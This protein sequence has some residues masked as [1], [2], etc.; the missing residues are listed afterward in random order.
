MV[1]VIFFSLWGLKK[2]RGD[3]EFV[4]LV[5]FSSFFIVLFFRI[6]FLQIS[7]YT[8]KYILLYVYYNLIC[9]ILYFSPIKQKGSDMK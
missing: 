6:V 7:L 8:M 4:V 5:V 2:D 3:D 1:F 9:N